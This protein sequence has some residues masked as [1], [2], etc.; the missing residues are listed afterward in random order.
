MIKG[1]EVIGR[2]NSPTFCRRSANKGSL[3]QTCVGVFFIRLVSDI[4]FAIFS[5]ET[6]SDQQWS[7][8]H[9][10]RNTA[11]DQ[12][13]LQRVKHLIIQRTCSTVAQNKQWRMYP[14]RWYASRYINQNMAVTHG[15][16]ELLPAD[17]SFFSVLFVW[18]Q[19]ALLPLNRFQMGKQSARV[20]GVAV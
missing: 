10:L 15:L 1:L 3:S 13:V 8:G 6:A 7:L 12:P 11:L 4:I 20:W 14:R 5:S 19:N 18:M 17:R 9:S 16:I 2:T